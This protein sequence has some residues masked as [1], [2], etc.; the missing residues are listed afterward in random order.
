LRGARHGDPRWALAAVAFAILVSFL[1]YATVDIA[2]SSVRAVGLAAVAAAVALN[3]HSSAPDRE[4]Q[5]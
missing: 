3:L 5:P 4:S 2:F 1:A